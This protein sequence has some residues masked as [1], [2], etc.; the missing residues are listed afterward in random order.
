MLST[1]RYLQK[2][3][4]KKKKQKNKVGGDSS[5]TT[6]DESVDSLQ[7]DH[8]SMES[9]PSFMAVKDPVV[10]SEDKQFAL[11]ENNAATVDTKGS[12]EVPDELNE[13][14]SGGPEST[15]EQTP[16]TPTSETVTQESVPEDNKST[17]QANPSK[18]SNTIKNKK[19]K[20]DSNNS[21]NKGDRGD[22][23]ENVEPEASQTRQSKHSDKKEQGQQQK[24][25]PAA[26]PNPAQEIKKVQFI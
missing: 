8:S 13:G 9:Q 10:P 26:E 3:K 17:V 16:L 22:Q 15:Q 25:T 5:D 20:N 1:R 4:R 24:V 14:E 6:V 19:H 18:K 11:S 21:K 2:N 7:E 23:N 12:A